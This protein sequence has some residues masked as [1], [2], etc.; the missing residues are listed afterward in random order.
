[1][2]RDDINQ[3]TEEELNQLIKQ[4]DNSFKKYFKDNQLLEKYVSYYISERI[5]SNSLFK[6]KLDDV[7]L[8]ALNELSQFNIDDCNY[9]I[10]KEILEKKYKLKI[11]NNNPLEIIKLF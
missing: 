7:I 11:I 10:I 5:K 8:T 6:Q 2:I 1:M 4:F 9:K 3:V